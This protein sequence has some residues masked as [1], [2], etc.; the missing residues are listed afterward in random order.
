MVPDRIVKKNKHDLNYTYGAYMISPVSVT[1]LKA[2]ILF[3]DYPT[4]QDFNE[5]RDPI[6]GVATVPTAVPLFAIDFGI[7]LA[8]IPMF[9]Y[10]IFGLFLF[11]YGRKYSFIRIIY[12]TYLICYVLSAFQNKFIAGDYV[13]I[14]LFAIIFRMIKLRKLT[15]GRYL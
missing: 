2:H 7:V 4:Y 15:L 3:P 11:I 6:A 12:F 13:Y 14:I 10:S 9:F 8:F 5:Y 1:L